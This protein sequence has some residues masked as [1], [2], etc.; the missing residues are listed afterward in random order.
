MD[1]H[2]IYMFDEKSLISIL[3]LKCFACVHLRDFDPEL[4]MEFREYESIYAEAKVICRM[5]LTTLQASVS[6]PSKSSAQ[7]RG[8]QP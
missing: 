4:D 8:P 5:W 1:G 2:H 6:S 3:K 7:I